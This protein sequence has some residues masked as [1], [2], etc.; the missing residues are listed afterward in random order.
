M[1]FTQAQ[2]DALDAEIIAIG[3][4]EA[5]TFADQSQKYRSIEE[6]LKLRAAMAEEIAASAG[7]SRT[8][9]AAFDK[10]V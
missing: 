3:A 6:L 2:L 10:G 1:P 4:V 5:T 9:W 8:R 7:S